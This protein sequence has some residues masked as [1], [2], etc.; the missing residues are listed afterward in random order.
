M[1]TVNCQP[2][3]KRSLDADNHGRQ[4]WIDLSEIVMNTPQISF[5]DFQKEQQIQKITQIL[6]L[7]PT[8]RIALVLSV[9]EWPAKGQGKVGDPVAHR[10]SGRTEPLS[11]VC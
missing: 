5:Q 1:L 4:Q 11:E 9:L 6:R 7:W 10:I 2:R 8:E 3:H